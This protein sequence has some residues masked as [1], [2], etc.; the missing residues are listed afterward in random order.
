[1]ENKQACFLNTLKFEAIPGG[2][3]IRLLE[4]FSFYSA[5]LGKVITAP[6][7]FVNDRESVPR[8]PLVFWLLG[9]TSEEGGV[10][11]DYSYRKGSKPGLNRRQAD[12][13]YYEASRCDGNNAV[14][15]ALK[16]FGVR[17]GGHGAWHKHE[18]MDD[19]SAE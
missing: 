9:D 18:V 6:K 5:E 17:I 4:D 7:G 13:L 10:L 11:H 19:V 3:Y 15:A 14:V 2:R 1:M 8:L 16:Q 12:A